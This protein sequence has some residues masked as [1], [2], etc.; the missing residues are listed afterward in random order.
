MSDEELPPNP[1]DNQVRHTVDDEMRTS[2]INYAMS[3][4]IGRALPEVRDGL[5]PVHRR[6]LFG[7]HEAGHTSDRSYSKSARSVGEVMGK[8]RPHGDQS[9]YDTMV[10]MAQDFSMRYE[11]VDGQ[12]GPFIPIESIENAPSEDLK[13]GLDKLDLRLARLNSLQSAMRYLPLSAPLRSYYIT[14]GFGKRRDPLNKRWAAHYGI[15]FGSH[16]KAKVFATAPGIVK[17]SGWKGR[18]GRFVEIDHGNGIVTRYGHLGKIYVKRGDKVKFQQKIG[19][20]GNS[21]RTTGPHLH[22]ETVFK[23]RAIN[24]KNFIKAGHYVFQRQ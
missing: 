3:V 21:G 1:T 4:I 11:L 17:V 2:Y 22:Y 7:M 14:S 19:L 24:P 10:R 13:K 15:D 9:I 16:I 5:K 23:G 12:G 8:Y 18:Y 20:L 6:V